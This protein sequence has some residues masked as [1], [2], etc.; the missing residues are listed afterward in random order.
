[1]AIKIITELTTTRLE[2]AVAEFLKGVGTYTLHYN[3][4]SVLIDYKEKPN[5]R[6]SAKSRVSA[7]SD[8]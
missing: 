8:K 4:T 2:K 3:G 5:G 7:S 6:K 1:M